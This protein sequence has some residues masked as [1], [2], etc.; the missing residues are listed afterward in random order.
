MPPPGDAI[1]GSYQGMLRA[2][3]LALADAKVRAGTVAQ[4]FGRFREAEQDL[5]DLEKG[6]DQDDTRSRLAALV[7][8]L[9]AVPAEQPPLWPIV[10]ALASVVLVL[11]KQPRIAAIVTAAAG[12]VYTVEQLAT[13]RPSSTDGLRLRLDADASAK[14]AR[15]DLEVTKEE[16]DKADTAKIESETRTDA[17]NRAVKRAVKAGVPTVSQTPAFYPVPY[18]EDPTGEK[19]RFGY[20]KDGAFVVVPIDTEVTVNGKRGKYSLS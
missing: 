7:L 2:A 17:E 16:Q 6:P 3:R 20:Y 11:V 9:E 15:E 4:V 12:G 13:A 8:S 1:K 5:K 14:K 19:K 10:P 18:K